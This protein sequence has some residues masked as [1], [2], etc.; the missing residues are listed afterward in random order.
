MALREIFGNLWDADCTVRVI[1]VNGF[2]KKSGLAVM[3]AGLARQAAQRYPNLPEVLGRCISNSGNHVH[4]L[5]H[6]LVAFPTKN[7]WQD[8]AD[9]ML[10]ER[11]AEELLKLATLQQFKLVALPR[12]GCGLG[13]LRWGQVKPIL[14]RVLG[15][16]KR[17]VIV[18]N[19]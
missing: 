12:V 16:D 7:D 11:S 6:D 2:V 8:P 3:G 5:R 15:E 18:D 13:G 1:P 4:M 9:L 17:F 14:E 10:I 19:S